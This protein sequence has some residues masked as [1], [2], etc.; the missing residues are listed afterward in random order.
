MELPIF[1]YN[2]VSITKAEGFKMKKKWILGLIVVATL[3]WITGC[4]QIVAG[5]ENHK[6]ILVKQDKAKQ[7]DVILNAG[8]G[9]L[10]VYGG[11]NEWV[12]GE[13]TYNS[14]DLKPKVKYKLTGKKGKVTID[15]SK[16]DLSITKLNNIKSVWDLELTDEIPINLE[17]NTGAS[18]TYLDLQGLQLSNL[19]IHAGVG[20]ITVDLSGNWK[21]SFDVDLEIGVGQSTIILPKDVGVKI[22][23][24]KGIGQSNFVGFIS[25]GN[26]VYVNQAFKDADVK[27]T[28]NTD[29]GVGQSNF[30]LE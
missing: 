17:I 29:L 23:S 25:E 11:A 13:A 5:K 6:N 7:I 15:Q 14:E 10:N 21:E 26:G 9:Q 18:E 22:K 4:S 3:L 16:K 20:D 12:E 27:I 1:A 24:S 19:D 2:G 30:E 8:I 28:V